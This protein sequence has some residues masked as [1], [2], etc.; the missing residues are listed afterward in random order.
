MGE[1]L[2]RLLTAGFV[3]EVQHPNWI[4][5]PV[6][7]PKKN[8]RWRMYVDYTS[9]N[10]ACLKGP[11]PLLR[12][13]QVI[14]LTARCELLSFLGAYS[15]YH[16]IP[17]AEADLP[18]T[19]FITPFGC[20]CYVKMLFGLKNAGATYHRCMQ[21]CFKGQIG[22]NLEVYVDNIIMTT[23]HSSRLITDLEETFSNLGH[24]N[25]KLNPEKC[26]F[27]VPR[28]K[29]LGYIIIKRGIE[30][31]L[32]KISAIAEIGQVR[33]V[34]DVQW[35]MGCLIALS[36]FVSQ[37][38]QRR[39]PLGKLLKKSDSFC[40]I[41]EMQKKLDNLKALIS[42][43]PILALPEPGETLLPYVMETPKS[44]APL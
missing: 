26:T 14:D 42:K 17:F 9:L 29:L 30:A 35:L 21:F 18:A 12:I 13:D 40:W 11:F 2:S 34:K 8:V 41:E 10:K 31:N 19:T 36:H 5:N 28:G 25:T 38:G 33:N 6:L 27:G 3:K 23:Q 15:S 44:S 7:V 32:D 37:L 20:F 39:L 43:P 4:D 16:P 1:E 22:R 24:F